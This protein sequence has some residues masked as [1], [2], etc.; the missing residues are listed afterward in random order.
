MR[1]Q[2]KEELVKKAKMYFYPSFILWVEGKR[3]T[4][5]MGKVAYEVGEY[6]DKYLEI[7]GY[8]GEPLQQA[9]R[10]M[11]ELKSILRPNLPIPIQVQE[12][13]F[14]PEVELTKEDITDEMER[15]IQNASNIPFCREW[16]GEKFEV[17]IDVAGRVHC[18]LKDLSLIP[19]G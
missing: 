14:L 8:L 4:N 6:K 7:K 3:L 1:E 12:T 10:K 13:R 11:N 5:Q 16:V 17:T 15:D 9:Y 19:E 2:K 18:V